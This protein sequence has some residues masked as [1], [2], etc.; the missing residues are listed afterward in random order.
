[1]CMAI[2]TAIILAA[3]KGNRLLPLTRTIPKCLVPIAETTILDHLLET[4]SHLG[5]GYVVIVVGYLGDAIRHRIGVHYNGIQVTYIEN[6][7][8]GYTDNISSLWYAQSFFYSDIL[9]IE[10]DIFMD[11]EIVHD[12]IVCPHRNVMAVDRV[13]PE[14]MSGTMAFL[15]S[16]G[17]VDRMILDRGEHHG[18]GLNL[19]NAYKIV[20]AYKLS[21]KFLSKQLMHRLNLHF[22]LGLT[23]DRYE[24]L[25]R[26]LLAEGAVRF[27][28]VLAGQRRWIDIDTP[29]DL[30][31]AL[32]IFAARSECRLQDSGCE[33]R[34][35]G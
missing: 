4:L 27:A 9:L 30:S 19:S 14:F 18:Q 2:D 15:D 24:V 1:M 33:L 25:I 13:N 35:K 16:D 17:M 3:G 32:Q 21:F 22:S 26:D 31:R 8:Y 11:E 5:I 34:I 28:P 23:D 29:E 6:P 10:G 7:L 20:N 12:L